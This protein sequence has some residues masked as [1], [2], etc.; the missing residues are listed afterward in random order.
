MVSCERVGRNNGD[1]GGDSTTAIS[2]N[3]LQCDN[4][5]MDAFIVYLVTHNIRTFL[6]TQADVVCAGPE[7]YAGTR[8]KELMFKKTNETLQTGI[9]T[10]NGVNS[11]S[12]QLQ[13]RTN[14]LASLLP[15][16]SGMTGGG[17]GGGAA[18]GGSAASLLSALTQAVPTLRNLPGVGQMLNAPPNAGFSDTSVGGVGGPTRG[19][20]SAIE[21]VR[22]LW[23]GAYG[24]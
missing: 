18:A 11:Q 10:L 23:I 16:L 15:A 17:A 6:P 20:E 9:Q 3:Q 21:Q 8:L 7:K 19:L 14:F 1:D 24:A 5:E 12:T 2:G 4:P 22:L 13:Q